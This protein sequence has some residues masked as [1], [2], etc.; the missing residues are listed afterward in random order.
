[1]V[2]VEKVYGLLNNLESALGQLRQ[3]A[4][5]DREKFLTDGLV[6]GAAKYYLQTA[7]EACIDIGNHIISSERYRSPRDYRDVF[8]VLQE[9]DIV[10]EDLAIRLRQMAGLRNRLVHLYWEIDDA[11]IYAYLQSNMGDFEA[12]MRWISDFLKGVALTQ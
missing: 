7:I 8:T 10:D 1:M 3:L 12:Y 5:T 6:L 9:N 2:N 4:I 11:L